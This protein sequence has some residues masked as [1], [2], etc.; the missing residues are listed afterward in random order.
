VVAPGVMETGNLQI[1]VVLVVVEVVVL[2]QHRQQKMAALELQI[3][4]LKVEMEQPLVMELA[5]VVVLVR[6]E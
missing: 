1:L 4:V 3:K 5:E 2:V 6:L